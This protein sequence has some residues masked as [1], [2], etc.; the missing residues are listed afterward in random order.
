M[1]VIPSVLT[2]VDPLGAD[3][4]TSGMNTLKVVEP[5]STV[6]VSVTLTIVPMSGTPTVLICVPEKLRLRR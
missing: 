5:T 6:I 4:I 2:G 3:T 1:V